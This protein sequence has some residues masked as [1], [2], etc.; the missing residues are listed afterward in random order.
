MASCF[1]CKYLKRSRNY[2]SQSLISDVLKHS[3]IL[4][5]TAIMICAWLLLFSLLKTA[6]QLC[7][8][9]MSKVRF[10]MGNIQLSVLLYFRTQKQSR[11]RNSPG[12][13]IQSVLQLDKETQALRNTA[14]LILNNQGGLLITKTPQKGLFNISLQ[15]SGLKTSV[16]GRKNSRFGHPSLSTMSWRF[17]K[18]CMFKIA[19]M[20]LKH[21]S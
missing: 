11:Y 7:S 19:G 17:S 12:N 15:H 9:S 16:R 18:L 14:K 13:G 8:N 20:V 2:S 3:L 1:L 6:Q 10:S 21:T 5:I 4:M